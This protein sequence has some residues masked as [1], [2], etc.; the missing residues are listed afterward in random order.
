MVGGR[1]IEI[2]D[3]GTLGFWVNVESCGEQS[4]IYVEKCA[5]SR[6]MALGDNLWWQGEHCMWTPYSTR[7]G[8]SHLAVGPQDIKIKKLSAC[9]AL[10][11]IPK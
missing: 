1:I 2:I 10:R 7:R 4:A 8:R 11:P 9:G 5:K 3:P 6:C